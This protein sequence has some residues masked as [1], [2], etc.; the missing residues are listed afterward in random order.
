MKSWKKP[1]DNMLEKVLSSVKKETDRQYFFSRLNNPLWIEPLRDRGYLSDPPSAKY[2]PDG[3]VQYPHWPELG[4]L[5]NVAHECPDHVVDIILSLPKSDN[6]R[7]YEDIITIALR[8][9]QQQSVKLLRKITEYIELNNQFLAQQFP[10]LLHYWVDLGCVEQA[11]EVSKLLVSFKEDPNTKQKLEQR[12][13][14]PDSPGSSLEPSP[15]FSEWEYQQI[16]EK[17]VRSLIDQEPLKTGIQLI[18]SVETM[19]RL[20]FH[21]EDLDK[22]RSEDYSEIWCQRVDKPTRDY[23]TEREILVHTLTYACEKVYELA[24]ESIVELDQEL[25]KPR[26]KL[27]SRLRQHLYALYPNDH[28]LPWIRQQVIEYDEYS[29]RDH[30]Y[31]F[32]LMIRKSC[33]HF[34]S[35][36]LSSAELK[37]ITDAVLS[38]P[39]KEDIK[40]WLGDAYD[41]D[42]YQKRQ[43]YFHRRQLHPFSSLLSGEVYEYFNQLE[44]ESQV[45][46]IEDDS[47]SPFV[48]VEGSWVSYQSPKAVG[49]LE[50]LADEDVLTYLNDW[51]DVH[52][53]KGNALVEIN[54]SALSDAFQTFFKEKVLRDDARLSFWIDNRDKIERPVYIS[55]ML[56]SFSELVKE[57]NFDGLEQWIEFNKWVLTLP[58]RENNSNQTEQSNSSR[59]NPDWSCSHRAVVDFIDTCISNEV[60]VPIE[61]RAG[62]AELLRIVC[63]QPDWRLDQNQRVILSSYDPIAEAINNTRSRALES[64]VNFGLWVRR[65]SPDDDLQEVTDIL[66]M[67]IENKKSPLTGPE[68]ALLGMHYSNLSK[69]NRSWAVKHLEAFFPK[70]NPSAWKNVFG[71]FLQ[72]NRPSM[73]A[74][75]VLRGEY[76]YAID[77]LDVL[78]PL[79]DKGTTKG[80]IDKLG[81]HIF[82][83]Y[84]W[85]VYSLSGVDS[86]LEHF[87]T[88]TNDSRVYWCRL[89]D[90]IG[91]MLRNSGKKLDTNLTNRIIEFFDWRFSVGESLEL[92]EFTFWLEAECLG[93]NWRLN[94]YSIILDHKQVKSGSLTFQVRTLNRLSNEH[95]ALSLECFSKITDAMNQGSQMYILADDAK[96]LIKKGLESENS[97]IIEDA[98]RSRENLL[99]LGRLDYMDI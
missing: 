82:T 37:A 11:L 8:L 13:K 50:N 31:E 14:N 30:H 66:D 44:A 20:G 53:E 6:P 97:K 3:Y 39:P 75:E 18:D 59:T 77:N 79:D 19:I 25:R 62:L 41:E 93:A 40:E 87:Y 2:L 89:F 88:N 98:K 23:Q 33:E 80:L 90:H 83:F 56:R 22:C 99:R 48:E 7:V 78:A 84:L 92:K 51:D 74:F 63:N 49:E 47:Y 95:L 58:I 46:S 45:K 16:L 10:D 24:P 52:H 17:G 73:P 94:A 70:D 29:K 15:Q 68:K 91:R 36:L 32:Q 54:F 43:R 38:G 27:F 61:A 35:S 67:R 42:A 1:T 76:E 21:A 4:Y 60:N 26:W 65:N 69:I 72:Y 96:R 28:N 9:D 12:K 71:S 57:N 34:S 5:I 86:L 85:G 55:A 64:L 81:Q